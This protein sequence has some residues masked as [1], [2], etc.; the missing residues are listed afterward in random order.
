MNP[1]VGLYSCNDYDVEHIEKILEKSLKENPHWLNRLKAGDKVFLKLNLLMKKRPNEAVTTHPALVEAVVRIIQKRKAHVIIGDSPG[2]PYTIS[3][4]SAIYRAC[5]IEEVAKK[6]NAELNYN[7][8]EERVSYPQGKLVKSFILLK[9]L[10]EADFVI[11]LSKLKTHMMMKYTGAVKNL[12]GIIPGMKKAD[13]HLRMPDVDNFADML[14][15]LALCVNADLHIMDAI[16][17][18]EGR[19]PSGGDLRQVG[20][21][22]ISDD[23]FALDVVATSLVKINP[24]S[25]PTVEKG[26]ERGKVGDVNSIDLHGNNISEW[27]IEPF[28]APKVNK[29]VRFPIPDLLTQPLRPK[30]VFNNSLCVSCGD[31]VDNCPPNALKLVEGK[32]DVNLKTCIRCYCCQELCPQKAVSVKRNFLGK[33]LER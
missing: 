29:T 10:W 17:G 16:V 8:A 25:V 26:L 27:K 6:T 19:G 1:T 21:L 24:L 13:Y 9:P 7:L 22:L 4:L 32:P 3:R 28:K 11:S 12:F 5:G 31:C 33:W 30:P 2:G 14:I 23:P 15:D 18:M 20:A